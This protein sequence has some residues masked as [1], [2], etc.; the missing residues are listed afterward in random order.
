MK[1][2]L[3]WKALAAEYGRYH[4]TKGNRLCHLIG[5]PLIVFSV[6][7]WT[8]V[9]SSTIPLAALGLPLYAL[10]EAELALLMTGVILVMGALAVHV[11]L[12]ATFAVFVVGWIFQFIG[13]GVYE[14]KSPALFDNLIHLLVGPMWVLREALDLLPGP[15]K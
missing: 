10:W 8:L 6:V 2:L 4:T 12:W 3:D 7:R 9:G 11:S 14:K 15:K 13:H 1:K 5:I